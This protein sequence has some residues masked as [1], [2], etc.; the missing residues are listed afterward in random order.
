MS[1]YVPTTER[2]RGRYLD[3]SLYGGKLYTYS[4]LPSYRVKEGFLEWLQ[5]VKAEA[6][7]EGYNWG[8]AVEG[9]GGDEVENPYRTGGAE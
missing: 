1:E 9:S 8:I 5:S 2:V 7:D 4:D 6:W 3:N